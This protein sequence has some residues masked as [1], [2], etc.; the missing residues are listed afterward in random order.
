MSFDCWADVRVFCGGD[1][2]R[3]EERGGEHIVCWEVGGL[4]E[5]GKGDGCTRDKTRKGRPCSK[6]EG[7]VAI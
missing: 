1:G 5:R 3:E 6:W 7:R 4:A 2:R